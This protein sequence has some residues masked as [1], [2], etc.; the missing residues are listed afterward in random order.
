MV[1]DVQYILINFIYIKTHRWRILGA[2]RSLLFL[3][4]RNSSLCICPSNRFIQGWCGKFKQI[5]GLLSKWKYG[6][7]YNSQI[8]ICLHMVPLSFS[9]IHGGACALVITGN[10]VMFTTIWGFF[11]AFD[12]EDGFE[13]STWWEMDGAE[14]KTQ[15]SVRHLILDITL[16]I[17]D[18]SYTLLFY[19]FSLCLL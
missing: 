6:W 7:V 4:H 12:N 3:Y 18:T 14:P 8:L 11:K 9:Q 5:D 13:Y 2:Q 16:T 15:M 1:Y 17:N 10:I 19:T